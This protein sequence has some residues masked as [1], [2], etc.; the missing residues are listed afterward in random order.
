MKVYVQINAHKLSIYA[1]IFDGNPTKMRM[2]NSK[3]YKNQ[4][5]VRSRYV[6]IAEV[7]LT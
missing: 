4:R 5:I 1:G 6:K 7:Y 3:D 2:I